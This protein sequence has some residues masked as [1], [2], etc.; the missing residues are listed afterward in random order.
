MLGGTVAVGVVPTYLRNP[1]ILDVEAENAFVLGINAQAY[2]TEALSLLAEWIVSE[3]RPDLENDAATFGL[4][5]ETRGHHFK[6]LVTNQ[7]RMN[8]AQ[9]LAG[10]P[11]A[12]EP[13]AWR[14]GFNITRLLPF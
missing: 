8:P 11:T 12:F 7:A 6:L 5:I 10:T 3:E 9:V 1:R 2:L 13:D 4:E 14:F